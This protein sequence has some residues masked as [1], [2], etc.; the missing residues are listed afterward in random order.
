MKLEEIDE[1]VLAR[2]IE[3]DIEIAKYELMKL[4]SV[5]KSAQTAY[6]SYGSSDDNHGFAI[7]QLG[8][9]LKE[10]EDECP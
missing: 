3:G 7:I 8:K 6:Q 10:L 9:A 4:V 2:L 1:W 5:A